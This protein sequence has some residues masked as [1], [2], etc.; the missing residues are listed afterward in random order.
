MSKEEISIEDVVS[1]QVKMEYV[2]RQKKR[3]C[4]NF[5]LGKK[6]PI[7]KNEGTWNLNQR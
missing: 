3:C 5:R 1:G 6:H 4:S 7:K 2:D